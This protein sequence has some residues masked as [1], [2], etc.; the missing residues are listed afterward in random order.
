MLERLKYSKEKPPLIGN[1]LSL[2]C[3]VIEI[4]IQRVHWILLQREK[5]VVDVIPLPWLQLE[6]LGWE[7]SILTN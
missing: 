5:N 4:R 7:Q 2:N 6:L 1:D 3:G